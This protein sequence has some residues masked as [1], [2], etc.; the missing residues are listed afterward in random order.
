MGKRDTYGGKAV[1]D[2]AALAEAQAYVDRVRAQEAAA[3]A[4]KT[5]PAE[6]EIPKAPRAAKRSKKSTTAGD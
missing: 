6:P 5:A 1:N 4:A 3:R 2:P